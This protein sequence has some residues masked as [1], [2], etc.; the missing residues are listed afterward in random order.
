[1][2]KAAT[3]L[4]VGLLFLYGVLIAPML[5]ILSFLVLDGPEG[6]QPIR[7]WLREAAGLPAAVV[8]VLHVLSLGPGWIL[9]VWG[10]GRLSGALKDRGVPAWI[11]PLPVVL[12]M[13]LVLLAFQIL[14]PSLRR[15]FLWPM[16]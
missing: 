11:R 6:L 1:M 4:L 16:V 2:R 12:G 10:Y 5:V 13:L 8:N 14:E 7:W 9:A 15:R 3:L